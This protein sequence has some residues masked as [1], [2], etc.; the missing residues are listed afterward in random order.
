MS[1]K[2]LFLDFGNVFSLFVLQLFY[3]KLREEGVTTLSAHRLHIIFEKHYWPLDSGDIGGQEF[4]ER[5]TKDTGIV[6][7]R[8]RFDEIFTMIFVEDVDGLDGLLSRVRDDVSISLISNTNEVHYERYIKKHPFLSA[9]IPH[10]RQFLSYKVGVRKPDPRI[11]HYALSVVGVRPEESVFIDD[12]EKN[13]EI[14][15]ALGGH[16]IVYHGF[17][18]DIS[19]LEHALDGYGLLK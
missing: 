17:H 2:A 15:K 18:H 11:Y 5:F 13:I 9:H 8:E 14:W 6:I 1:I 12:M 16:G 3:A 10:E 4:Y 19:A 7:S